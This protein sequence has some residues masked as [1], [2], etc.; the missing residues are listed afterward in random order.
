MNEYTSVI[1]VGRQNHQNHKH[2]QLLRCRPPFTYIIRTKSIR[3]NIIG[4]LDLHCWLTHT[5]NFIEIVGM[6][7]Q[8]NEMTNTI[9]I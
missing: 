6:H 4:A 3:T 1:G 8:L 5:L 9:G 2:T 7:E